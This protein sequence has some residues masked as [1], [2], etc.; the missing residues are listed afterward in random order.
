MH[1]REHPVTARRAK[2]KLPIYSALDCPAHP[3]AVLFAR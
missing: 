2:K 1:A 3:G